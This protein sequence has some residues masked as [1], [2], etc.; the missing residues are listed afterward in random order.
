MRVFRYCADKLGI[1]R[2]SSLAYFLS[3]GLFLQ[4]PFY[5]ARWT[6]YPIQL[7]IASPSLNI[8]YLK[9]LSHSCSK[10]RASWN[11]DGNY[12]ILPGNIHSSEIIPWLAQASSCIQTRADQTCPTGHP[13][14]SQFRH[15]SCLYWLPVYSTDVAIPSNLVSPLIVSSMPSKDVA[16]Q[17]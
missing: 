17:D 6:G 10:I 8:L 13:V 11:H 3:L 7:S 4:N 12:T 2:G 14:A 1:W 16:W 9:P 15:T 5:I